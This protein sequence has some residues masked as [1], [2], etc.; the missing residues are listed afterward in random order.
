MCCFQETEYTDTYDVSNYKHT[1]SIQN[2]AQIKLFHMC[3]AGKDGEYSYGS[4]QSQHQWGQYDD[5]E[6]TK[7][8]TVRFVILNGSLDHK[9][10]T[11]TLVTF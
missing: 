4:T 7:S 9:S 1:G 10:L 5:P 6:S 11:V 8:H 3:H 2:G